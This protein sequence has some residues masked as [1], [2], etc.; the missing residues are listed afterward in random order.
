MSHGARESAAFYFHHDHMGLMNHLFCNQFE[1]FLHFL[2]LQPLLYG[3]Q[4]NP[5]HSFMAERNDEGL[6]FWAI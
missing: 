5:Q 2:Y 6:S 1:V 4:Y 3:E